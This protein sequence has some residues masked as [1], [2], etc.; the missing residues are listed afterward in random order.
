MSEDLYD[1]SKRV[2]DTLVLSSDDDDVEQWNIHYLIEF[3]LQQQATA[4]REAANMYDKHSQYSLLSFREKCEQQAKEL[5]HEQGGIMEIVFMLVVFFG[6][7]TVGSLLEHEFTNM[8]ECLQRAAEVEYVSQ[9]KNTPVRATC[10]ARD[11]SKKE[12]AI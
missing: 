7:K 2:L 3:A 11:K 10:V 1:A 9:I 4:W 12:K 6:D 5:E 8:E